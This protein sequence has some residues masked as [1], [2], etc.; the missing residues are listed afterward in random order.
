MTNRSSLLS[1]AL[2]L[3]ALVF[4]ASSCG[5]PKH[6]DPLTLTFPT[7]NLA[8]ASAQA[9][10]K[11]INGVDESG[12]PIGVYSVANT[13][14]MEPLLMGGDYIVVDHRVAF[15]DVKLGQPITYQAQWAPAPAP[16]VTHRAT[17]RDKDGLIVEGDNV[18]PD[19]VPGTGQDEHTE[20]QY[21]VTVAN[22]VGTVDTIYRVKP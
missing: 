15:A 12:H 3:G 14:S 5:Y 20:N 19:I 9:R 6:L 1:L 18:T 22:Y 11:D 13:H 17:V 10:A 2:F 8:L 21:R 4:L 7:Q 16:P